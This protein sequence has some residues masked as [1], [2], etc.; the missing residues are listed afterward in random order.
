MAS[1]RGAPS[2]GR[3]ALV[4]PE[5][6][7]PRLGRPHPEQEAYAHAQRVL[8]RKLRE[9]LADDGSEESDNADDLTAPDATLGSLPLAAWDIRGLARSQSSRNDAGTSAA[10]ALGA[11]GSEARRCR[12]GEGCAG[13]ERNVHCQPVEALARRQQRQEL[14][15]C[16]APTTSSSSGRRRA[17]ARRQQPAPAPWPRPWARPRSADTRTSDTGDSRAAAAASDMLP[18]NWGK[19]LAAWQ[20]NGGRSAWQADEDTASRSLVLDHCDSEADALAAADDVAD[21]GA[22]AAAFLSGSPLCA[23]APSCPSGGA[24]ARSA[25]GSGASLATT[26]TTSM[27]SVETQDERYALALKQRLGSSCQSPSQSSSGCA[28]ALACP[29]ELWQTRD[30]RPGPACYTPKPITAAAPR[31][32]IG[33]EVLRFGCRNRPHWLQSYAY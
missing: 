1:G 9:L 12:G 24:V 25:E 17:C 4:P 14:Q 10:D 26:A 30:P 22:D 32:V 29:K 20:R 28:R 21:D 13:A 8:Q 27:A 19:A 15:L 33:Q 18:P 3:A 2:S 23:V 16:K 6:I 31:A 11:E 5:R 7:S